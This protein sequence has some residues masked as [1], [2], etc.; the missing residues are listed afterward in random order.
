MLKKEIVK[1]VFFVILQEQEKIVSK[2]TT[3]GR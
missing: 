2:N 1:Y 3:K